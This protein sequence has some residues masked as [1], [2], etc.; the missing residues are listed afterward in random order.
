MNKLD[1]L[2]GRETGVILTVVVVSFGA[3]VP[4]YAISHL[5]LAPS[6]VFGWSTA[7]LG[8][9]AYQFSKAKFRLDLFEKKMAHL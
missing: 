1:E 5:E 4:L 7:G 9:L 6:F 8:L 2:S 3:L